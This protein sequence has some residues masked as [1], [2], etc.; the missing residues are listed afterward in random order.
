MTT[1]FFH[2]SLL[3]LF[4]DPEWVKVRI[5]DKHPGSATLHLSVV[6]RRGEGHN[7]SI[8]A[9]IFTDRQFLQRIYLCLV[10]YFICFSWLYISSY[11]FF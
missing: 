6:R 9:A 4:W 3:L 5:W 1:N 7:I 10:F 11:K 8:K 2:P